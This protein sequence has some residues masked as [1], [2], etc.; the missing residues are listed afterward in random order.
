MAVRAELIG[1]SAPIEEERVPGQTIYLFPGQG[2]QK[3]GMGKTLY[4]N[5]EIAREILD[6]LKLVKPELL[7]TMFNGPHGDQ[8]IN[9]LD[10]TANAQPA[11]VAVSIAAYFTLPEANPSF[12]EGRPFGYLGHSTGQISAIGSAGVVG[13][14]TALH[15]AAERG[16]LMKEVGE[17]I[18]NKGGMLVL[19]EATLEK[20]ELLC[21][22]TSEA[23]REKGIWVAN[24]NADDQIVLSGRE[25]HIVYAATQAKEAGIMKAKRLPVSIPAHSPLMKE[26]QDRF[27][28]YLDRIKFERPTSPIFLNTTAKATSDPE[29]IK[30]DLISGLTRGV[31][32]RESLQ[33]AQR[34]GVTSFVE[35]GKGPLSDFAQKVIP[36]SKRIQIAA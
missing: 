7:E 11:I 26:A 8:P 21:A 35:I 6:Q 31:R 29:E 3:I 13:I 23:L 18:D 2:V 10:D 34:M 24:Y 20:A 16:R 19:F 14:K 9:V 17:R 1:V 22:N 30:A 15:M 36:D 33:E 4:K 12:K 5:S 28:Q 27:E 25:H 32:F